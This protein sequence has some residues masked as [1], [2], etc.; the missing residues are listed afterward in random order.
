MSISLLLASALLASP[1]M[2]V[3][4]SPPDVDRVEVAYDALRAGQNNAAIAQIEASGLAAKGDAAALI[5]LGAA[6]ARVGRRDEAM[7]SFR[8]AIASADRYDLQLADGS[9]ADSRDAA[10]RA[11]RALNANTALA[12]R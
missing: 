3:V 5:N 8:A 6:Y 11:A 2:E 7:A 10:R 12:M 4:A 1:A 9:W